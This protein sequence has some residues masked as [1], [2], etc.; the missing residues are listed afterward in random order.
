LDKYVQSA[1]PVR[2]DDTYDPETKTWGYYIP[3]PMGPAVMESGAR[4]RIDVSILARSPFYP[5][6]DAWTSPSLKEITDADWSFGPHR[7]EDGDPYDYDGVPVMTK[8]SVDSD[9]F[10]TPINHYITVY[11]KG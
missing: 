10:K 1:R 9:N 7:K 2:I 5:Y 3:L 6:Q 11:R 4:F 8:E